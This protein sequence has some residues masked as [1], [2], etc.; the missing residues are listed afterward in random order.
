[1]IGIGYDIH[2][3]EKNEELVLGGVRFDTDFGTVAHSDGDVLVHSIIDSLLGAAGLGDIGDHFPDNDE[4]YKNSNSMQLLAEVIKLLDSR[5]LKILN[6][7]ATIVLEKPKLKHYKKLMSENIAKVCK[8]DPKFVNIKATTNEKLGP[9]GN[10][11]GIAVFS[12]A[13]LISY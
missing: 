10:S 1:M 11:E 4:Q 13:E 2:R 9:I 5:A 7:D 8:I 3:L 6:I 12:A